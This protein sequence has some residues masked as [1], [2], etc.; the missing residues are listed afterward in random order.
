MLPK[1]MP[2]QRDKQDQNHLI[3][4]QDGTFFFFFTQDR[5]FHV[6][7]GAVFTSLNSTQTFQRVL[8]ALV[9]RNMQVRSTLS[10]A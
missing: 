8:T 1:L 6:C 3:L 4:N 5:Y 9:D 2:A 7:F 10:M